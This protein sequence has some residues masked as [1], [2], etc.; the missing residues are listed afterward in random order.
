MPIF[1]IITYLSVLA[2]A[3]V[4][5]IWSGTLIIRMIAEWRERRAVGNIRRRW[6]ERRA[7]MG[8]DVNAAGAAIPSASDAPRVRRG[9]D[10]V[11]MVL[12]PVLLVAGFVIDHAVIGSLRHYD[13]IS[14]RTSSIAL[15]L[16]IQ[17]AGAVSFVAA[18]WWLGR[19]LKARSCPRCGYDMEGIG[20]SR[21]PECGLE[22]TEEML[23]RQRSRRVLLLLPIVLV[24]C[25]Y[26][27]IKW[28]SFGRHGWLSLVPTT[29]MIAT[30]EHLPAEF[31]L[32]SAGG[33]SGALS[34][35]DD[36]M[37]DWQ[38]RWLVRRVGSV[39]G[40]SNGLARAAVAKDLCEETLSYVGASDPAML[41]IMLG[42]MSDPDPSLRSFGGELLLRQSAYVHLGPEMRDAFAKAAPML[43]PDLAPAYGRGDP[44]FYT[45]AYVCG[46]SDAHRPGVLAQLASIIQ[47]PAAPASDV[48][49]A[50]HTMFS[51]CGYY[52]EELGE[53]VQ[54]AMTMQP[55]H[56]RNVLDRFTYVK[57]PSSEVEDLL[58]V[59]TAYPD[60][61][62]SSRAMQVLA[63]QL[64]TSE[65][66][67]LLLA[68][69]EE[70]GRDPFH[71]SD[72]EEVVW[73]GDEAV[74]T[75]ELRASLLELGEDVTTPARA[76]VDILVALSYFENSRI[77]SPGSLHGRLLTVAEQLCD[78]DEVGAYEGT[79]LED[80]LRALASNL[81]KF[82]AGIT[83]A[84]SDE[85][86]DDG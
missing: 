39:I 7:K 85:I 66:I 33:S 55:E 26:L 24:V 10:V 35:R 59:M 29:G 50:I 45:I 70:C 63:S 56:A 81:H 31:V 72:L 77:A 16:I 60:P 2:A 11:I 76:R 22:S 23:T 80:L 19:T 82:E 71:F 67:Q 40:T 43:F 38:K 57:I 46:F 75:D 53:M 32:E 47:D 36:E 48:R 83:Q 62:V 73:G 18:W 28:D 13:M 41:E 12:A 37:W 86:G 61:G 30:F 34:E 64:E 49:V 9:R 14:S 68:T 25:S 27:T 17:I 44:N 74:L 20:G 5:S 52:P 6:E 54:L 78:T 51:I 3:T 42:W 79:M 4:L 8:G 69:F 58:E 65:R 21:C 84:E 15:G 1:I